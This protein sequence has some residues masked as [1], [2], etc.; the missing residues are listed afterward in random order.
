MCSFESYIL[1]CILHSF[2]YEAKCNPSVFFYCNLSL[3]QRSFSMF[4]VTCL[5][6]KLL[7]QDSYAWCAHAHTHTCIWM[8]QSI[9]YILPVA[10]GVIFLQLSVLISPHLL[11]SEEIKLLFS[12]VMDFNGYG[13]LNSANTSC[14]WFPS[15]LFIMNMST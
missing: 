5:S 2:T 10:V 4:S 6:F 3:D 1:S 9:L 14:I 15:V 7:K 11:V 13:W 12:F 8:V